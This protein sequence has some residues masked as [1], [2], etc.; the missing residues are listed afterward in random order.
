MYKAPLKIT[1]KQYCSKRFEKRLHH[2]PPQQKMESSAACA[3]YAI[4]TAHESN[5]SADGTLAYIHTP[6]PHSPYM[7][8]CIPPKKPS[9]SGFGLSSNIL[10]LKSTLAT[11]PN[12]ISQLTVINQG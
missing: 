9:C 7:L 10:D 3:I 6:V 12:V 4:H 8:H 5:Y 1:K 11:T 2:H